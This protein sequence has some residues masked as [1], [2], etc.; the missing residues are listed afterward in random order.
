MS[1]LPPHTDDDDRQSG[2][3]MSEAEFQAAE[4]R[5]D[6]MDRPRGMSRA[7]WRQN[8]RR[9]LRTAGFFLVAVIVG[10]VIAGMSGSSSA[11]P[12]S[13]TKGSANCQLTSDGFW[14]PAW[15]YGG[16]SL[17]QG[18]GVGK[19]PSTTGAQPTE[20]ELQQSGATSEETSEAES[21][22]QASASDGGSD[23]SGSD[24][25]DGGGDSSDG[26]DSGGDAGGGGGDGGD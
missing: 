7:D 16:L 13:C 8:Q 9:T 19:A 24:G 3:R 10:V 25:S 1:D 23:A 26:G 6:G 22:A 17:A 2:P 18:T 11:K 15:Y 21:Y 14:V 4:D 5:L 12:P 20:E